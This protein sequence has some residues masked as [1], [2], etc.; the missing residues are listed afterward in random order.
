MTVFAHIGHWTTSLAF[1]AP[2]VVLPLGLFLAA[3]FSDRAPSDG[4][5]PE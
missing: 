1:F 5:S 4:A 3:R 2:V